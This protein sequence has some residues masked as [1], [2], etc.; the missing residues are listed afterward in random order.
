MVDNM[1]YY[2]NRLCKNSKFFLWGRRRGHLMD[3]H[4]HVT[5]INIKW[6]GYTVIFLSNFYHVYTF[7]LYIIVNNEEVKNKTIECVPNHWV[8]LW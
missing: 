1:M 2:D 8:H 7:L 5:A 6:N 3:G 4:F